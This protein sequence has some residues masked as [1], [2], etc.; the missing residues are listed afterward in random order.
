MG[1]CPSCNSGVEKGDVYCR[2]CGDELSQED[3]YMCD[4]GA[5]VRCED[6][7][8]HQC[9]ASF[10]D[11]MKSCACGAEIGPN[12]NFCPSCGSPVA[13]EEPAIED[14]VIVEEEEHFDFSPID[15]TLQKEEPKPTYRQNPDGTYTFV[16]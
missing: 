10:N 5:E 8:C 13:R 16:R 15:N 3:T 7:Y 12:S 6:S 4:C 14:A 1:E 11:E 2:S 9:G